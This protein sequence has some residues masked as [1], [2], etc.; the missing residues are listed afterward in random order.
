MCS[1]CEA[2]DQHDKPG[3]VNAER[4]ASLQGREIVHCEW[5]HSACQITESSKLEAHLS[6]RVKKRLIECGRGISELGEILDHQHICRNPPIGRKMLQGPFFEAHNGIAVRLHE[7]VENAVSVSQ[8]E[9]LI[10]LLS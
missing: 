10:C 3:H 7:Q 1:D 6:G 9:L 2:H 5:E 4:H 8:G